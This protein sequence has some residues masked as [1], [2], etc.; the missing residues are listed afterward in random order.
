MVRVVV[1]IRV[2]DGILGPITDQYF[3]QDGLL[4]TADVTMRYAGN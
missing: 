3:G 1:Q 2:H 4:L